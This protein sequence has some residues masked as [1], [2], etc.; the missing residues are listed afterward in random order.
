[1]R[2]TSQLAIF[3]SLVGLGGSAVWTATPGEATQL[4]VTGHDVVTGE[5]S[6]SYDPACSA[7]DHHIEFGPLANVSTLGYSGQECG[8]GT[9]GL[10]D[11]FAPGEGSYFFLVVGNDGAGTEGSYGTSFISGVHGERGQDLTDP[12]CSFVQDLSDRCDGRFVR[13]SPIAG[14]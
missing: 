3:C 6:I 10:Y 1:M 2:R 12:Q 8:M 9:S 13:R 7:A 5:L 4:R 11:S 14:R